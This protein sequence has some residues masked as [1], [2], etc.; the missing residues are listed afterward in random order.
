MYS[1]T[2]G[3]CPQEK[4]LDSNLEKETDL[5]SKK[6]KLNC[7]MKVFQI[8]TEEIKKR[9]PRETLYADDLALVVE[10]VVE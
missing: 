10:S 8:V 6:N 7:T 3:P 9:C 5:G 4:N 1:L 2:R